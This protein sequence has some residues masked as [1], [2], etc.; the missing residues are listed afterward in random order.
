MDAS[1]IIATA[2]RAAELGPTLESLARVRRSGSVELI[3]V[4]NDSADD[5]SR[6]VEQAATWYPYPVRYLFEPEPGKYAALNTGIKAAR[7]RRRNRRRGD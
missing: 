3:V 5:A 7:G 4:D 6:V 2:N 1:I